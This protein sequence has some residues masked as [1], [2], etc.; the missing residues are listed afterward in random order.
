MRRALRAA[1]LVVAVAVSGCLGATVDSGAPV[2]QTA[3]GSWTSRAPMPSARQEVAVAVLGDQIFVIGGFGDGAAPTPTVESYDVS[4]DTWQPRAPLP[5]PVHHAAAAV[6]GGRLYVVGGYTGGRMGW[7]RSA[8]LFEYDPVRGTWITRA[9]MPTAR[10]ALAAVAMGNRLHA[11]GGDA[12]GVTGAHEVFDPAANRWHNAATMPTARDHL[13][14]VTAAGRIWVVG[15]RTSFFGTQYANVEIYDP[16]TDSW[17]TGP[18][19]PD[20][21]G[22]LAAAA[23]NDRIY[24]FGGEAPLRIFSSSEMYEAAG[25]RWIGKAAMP[26]PRHGIGAAVVAG[27]IYIPGGATSPGL[28][29]TAVHEV[30]DP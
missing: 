15:G 13:A 5:E 25:N 4:T 29:R 8:A 27:R 9:P 30:F 6:V 10:G 3:S 12:D 22:G 23:I 7:T 21:R 1:V 2:D 24:V 20:A 17:R 11:L 16:A 19:L 18:P 26:T 14:A 28:A